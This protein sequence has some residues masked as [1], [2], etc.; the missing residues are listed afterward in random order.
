[1]CTGYVNIVRAVLRAAAARAGDRVHARERRRPPL[2]RRLRPRRGGRAARRRPG[3]LHRRPRAAAHAPRRDAAQPARPRAHRPPSTRAAPPA[4]PGV[5]AVLTGADAAASIRARSGP[6]IPTTSAVADY[7]LAVDRARYVGEPVAAVAAVDRATAEDALERIRVEYEPLPAVRR[8]GAGHPRPGR[9]S[10]TRSSAPTSSGTTRS[11]T[12]TSTARCARADGVLRERFAIQRY[13]STPLETF[14]GIAE[15]D[16]GTRRYEFWTN[17]QRPG[18]TI[19]SPRR[20]ARRAAAAAPAVLPGHRRRLR[21]QAA[22]GVS[23]RLRAARAEGRASRQVDRGPHREPHRADARVQRR[24][25]GRARLRRRRH[26]ARPARARRRR[27]GQEPPH[28]DPAQPDQARQ[29]R[30]RL[31]HP[32]HPLRGVVGPHQQVPERA[33]TAA[34]A[35]RSCASPSSARWRCWRGA[36]ALDPAELRLQNYVTAA[37]MPYTTPPGAQYDSGDYPATLRARAATASTTRAGA[38]EQARA[39]AEGP[40][41]RHRHRDVGRA[42]GDEPRVVRDHHRPARAPPARRRRRWCASSRTARCARRWAIRRAARRYETVIA[43]IVADELGCTPDAG[44]RRPRL[45][46]GD[47]AVALPLGQLLE[48]VLG[49]RRRRHRGGRRGACATSSC[50]S[51]RIGSRSTPPTSS[52]ATAPPSCAGRPTA[53]LSFAE[54]ARTAY[55]DVLGL[56]A[57]RGARPRGAP[58]PPE[59]ARQPDRRRTG[60]CALSSSSRT[61]PTAASWRWTGARGFVRILKLRRRAR[62][63]ARDEPVDRR[64]HGARLDRPRHRRG[65]ARGVPLRRARPAPHLDVH[66][67]PQA[68]RRSTSP[69]SRWT[70]SSIPRP[71]TPLGAKGVGEGGAIPGPAAVANAV[72]DALQPFGAV[73][74]ELPLT[75]ERVWRWLAD[76]AGETAA[77]G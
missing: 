24:D 14:G 28:A 1:M 40:A 66:G 26:G 52:C 71:F 19:A 38:A 2:G 3:P 44:R 13:A 33:P 49:H 48:Q 61:P 74:R 47:D 50:A 10:S 29:H 77:R 69:I 43:Q 31:P 12:A 65:A 9:R 53:R 72:E 8:P 34:S 45:R 37:E 63:R 46:L 67:L 75:P 60:A 32:R 22:P 39:R 42:R 57:G 20:R 16:A 70:V 64:G 27:R 11:P 7:C 73:V 76:G 23:R 21:Q 30:Q 58:R 62:L 56:A 59:P 25:G 41:A 17:D 54:L 36:S 4:L 5:L 15:Y 6:L 18:L 55:A 35:S 68:D 51:P